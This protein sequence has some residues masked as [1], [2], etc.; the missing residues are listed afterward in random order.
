MASLL[1]KACQEFHLAFL[2]SILQLMEKILESL[3]KVALPVQQVVQTMQELL[4]I[5]SGKEAV[6]FLQLRLE[7][8]EENCLASQQAFEASGY[9][10]ALLEAQFR[11]GFF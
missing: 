2:R 10:N 1:F 4:F 6:F 5:F 7:M 3:E 9:I 8:V 11:P